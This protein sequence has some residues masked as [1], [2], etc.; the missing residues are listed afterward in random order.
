MDAISSHKIEENVPNYGSSI[1]L[2]VICRQNYALR[3]CCISVSLRTFNKK[4]VAG[5]NNLI[6]SRLCQACLLSFSLWGINLIVEGLLT[7]IA[8]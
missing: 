5:M 8:N 4:S 1:D 6:A 2:N 7:S 3:E